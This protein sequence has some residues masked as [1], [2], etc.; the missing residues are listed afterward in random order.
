MLVLRALSVLKSWIKTAALVRENC[1]FLGRRR[2]QKVIILV[3]FVAAIF[4]GVDLDL[5]H[6]D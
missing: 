4:D 5:R 6:K 1:L 3:A 2:R